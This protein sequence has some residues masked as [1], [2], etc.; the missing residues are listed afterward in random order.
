MSGKNDRAISSKEFIER[1]YGPKL[2]GVNKIA[3]KQMLALHESP[4]DIADTLKREYG[5]KV[6]VRMIYYYAQNY[7]NEIDE[8]RQKLGLEL[9]SIPVANKFQRIMERQKLVDELSKNLWVG[10]PLIK[11]GK[12]VRDEEGNAILV[13]CSRGNHLAINKILD[14][15]AKELGELEEGVTQQFDILNLINFMTAAQLRRFVETGEVP[16][17]RDLLMGK[18]KL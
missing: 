15:V 10:E 3:I 17:K 16:E 1:A 9:R 12:I 8:I 7:K 18:D 11:K 2:D 5:I 14:S 4:T 6:S 13:K